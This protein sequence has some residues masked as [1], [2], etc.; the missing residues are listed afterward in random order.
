MELYCTLKKVGIN[1]FHHI[2]RRDISL[3]IDHDTILGQYKWRRRD[4][5]G[6][7][8]SPWVTYPGWGQSLGYI[9]VNYLLGEWNNKVSIPSNKAFQ[10]VQMSI[11]VSIASALV[12]C[13]CNPVPSLPRSCRFISRHYFQYSRKTSQNCLGYILMERKLKKY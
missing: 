9:S 2:S 11:S 1:P 13:Q 7:F 3:S 5:P 8:M 10:I 12:V 4:S 6:T